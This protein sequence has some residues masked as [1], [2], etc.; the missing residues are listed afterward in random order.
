[1][2]N[3]YTCISVFIGPPASPKNVIVG[4]V[5]SPQD[6]INTTFTISWSRSDC[7][8][9]YVVA[10]SNTSDDR[11]YPNITTTDNSTT[12]RLPT[13]VEFCVTVVG[14]DSIGRRGSPSEPKCYRGCL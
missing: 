3:Y 7:A 1:M 13:G 11:V 6:T 5:P 4:T 8:V 14:V 9:E 2:Y 10:I 12:V